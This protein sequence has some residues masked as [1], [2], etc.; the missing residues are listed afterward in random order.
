MTETGDC[1]GCDQ[2]S[3]SKTGYT[4]IGRITMAYRICEYN[5]IQ[6]DQTGIQA[7]KSADEPETK[8]GQSP[9]RTNEE[10]A[11]R[12]THAPSIATRP[13]PARDP[14]PTRPRPAP[15]PAG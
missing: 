5:L 13:R 6:F 8:H 11:V 12:D 2:Y 10:P 14:P 7:D 1:I 4:Y 9:D 3:A 15:D